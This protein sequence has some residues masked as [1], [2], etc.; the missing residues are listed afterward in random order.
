ME[1][2]GKFMQMALDLARHGWGTTAPNPM[3][4]AVIVRNGEVI[5]RGFHLRAG[6]PHAEINAINDAR[7]HGLPTDGSTLYV[8]LEPCSTTGRTGPCTE[9]IIR[10][11]MSRVVIGVLDPNPKHRGAAVELL[12]KANIKVD[13][14]VMQDDCAK[15]NKPFFKWITTGKPYVML[16]LATTLDGRIATATGKSTWI[17]GPEARSRVQRLRRLAGAIMVGAATARNDRP[18]LTVREPADWPCQP[19][20]LVASSS[21]GQEEL[22][23]IFPDGNAEIVHADGPDE[24]EN[25][26][27]VLGRRGITALLIEGGG[28][29][30]ASALRAEVVDYVEFHVAPKIL[31][32]RGSRPAVGGPDPEVIGDAVK[33]SDMRVEIV[34][35][36]IVI[37]GTPREE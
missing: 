28:E 4:G 11:E 18:R 21:M 13:V 27:D 24:W 29:L 15:L 33:L 19:L 10:A 35:D 25:L 16:K 6:S 8:T 3:V 37:S 14:G 36:D 7:E 20:R 5:G 23:D 9:A 26:L 31:G 34:G 12:E 22:D 17:T 32:G 30:A 2:D 1:D